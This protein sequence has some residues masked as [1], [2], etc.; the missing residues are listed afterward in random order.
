M[1]MSEDVILLELSEEV[2]LEAERLASQQGVS[3]D[4]WIAAA[5]AE[6]VAAVSASLRDEIE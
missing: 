5:V 2:L 3:L 1:C 4:D 6:R